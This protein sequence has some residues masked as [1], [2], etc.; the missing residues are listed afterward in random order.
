MAIPG[1]SAFLRPALELVVEYKEINQAR[2]TLTHYTK[3]LMGFTDEEAAERLNSGGSRLANRVGWALT[4]LKKAGLIVFPARGVARITPEGEEFLKNHKG[5]IAV[6]DLDQFASFKEF[7]TAKNSPDQSAVP[8]SEE[9]L[10]PEDRIDMAITEIKRTVA[11]DLLERLRQ[12]D[13]TYFEQ[14]VL[15]LLGKMQYGLNHGKLIRTGGSGDFGID[16]IIYMDRLG[17]DKIYLQAK[18]WKEGNVVGRPDIQAFYGALAGKRASRGVFITTSKFTKDALDFGGSVSDSLVLI[19]G[20][21][22][23]LLMV[24]YEVGVNS[25]KVLT[26]PEIDQDY[27][28]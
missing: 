5:P 1:F 21:Q 25:K 8:E 28:E 9:E 3:E 4:Y 22:L 18:R 13:P 14:V 16:G 17:L 26:I 27:F 2:S 6:K 10:D 7:R 20:E 19:D 12:V 11:S 24:E 23:A 15:D